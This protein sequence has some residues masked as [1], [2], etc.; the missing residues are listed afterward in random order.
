MSN[1]SSSP[2]PNG[3]DVSKQLTARERAEVYLELYKQQM[4]YFHET[5]RIEFQANLALWTAIGELQG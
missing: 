4:A 3:H 1:S 5:R 2:A